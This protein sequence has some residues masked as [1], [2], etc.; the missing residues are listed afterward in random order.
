[1]HDT[2]D[3]RNK[4]IKI[5]KNMLYKNDKLNKGQELELVI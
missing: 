3:E 4:H 1:M 2:L 5:Y